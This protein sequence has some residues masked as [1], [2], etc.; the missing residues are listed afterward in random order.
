MIK[1]EV[2]GKHKSY[3]SKHIKDY[4]TNSISLVI[5]IWY[6]VNPMKHLE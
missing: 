2:H 4:I 3:I 1:G 6:Y 5:F